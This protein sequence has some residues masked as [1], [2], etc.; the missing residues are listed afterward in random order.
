MNPNKEKQARQVA[1]W[2]ELAD[3]QPVYAL[4]ANVDLV[5]VRYDEQVSVLYGRC[6]HRGALLSDG[7]VRGDNLICGIHNWD[8][9]Y[10]SGIS[11]YNNDEA[12]LT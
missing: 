9:R 7:T 2:S 3:R 8:Y 11:A 10:D 4:A 5:I 1:I 12:L 6:L